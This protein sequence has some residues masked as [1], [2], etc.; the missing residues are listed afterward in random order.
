MASLSPH[1]NTEI[2]LRG[3]LPAAS[4]LLHFNILSAVICS[5]LLTLCVTLTAN[6][7]S[8]PQS[9]TLPLPLAPPR[10]VA[11]PAVDE[12]QPVWCASRWYGPVP[13][14]KH[15]VLFIYWSAL[16]YWDIPQMLQFES[17][18]EVLHYWKT[19]SAHRCVLRTRSMG[20]GALLTNRFI[21]QCSRVFWLE[22]FMIKWVLF[23]LLLFSQT[24]PTFSVPVT[25]ASPA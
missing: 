10:S 23:Q 20:W 15:T 7:P 21:C 19:T 9:P 18:G 14:L 4:S 17:S 22:I 25:V 12:A 8:Y 6:S 2:S 16:C 11:T 5:P 1:A 3:L 24:T 13:P